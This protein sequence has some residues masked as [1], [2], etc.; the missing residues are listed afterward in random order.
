MINIL[1]VGLGNI[2]IRHLQSLL[3][4]ELE[5]TIYALEI[6]SSRMNACKVLLNDFKIKPHIK[7]NFLC[8]LKKI[9]TNI[10]IAIISTSSEGRKEL[11]EK[12]IKIYSIDYFIIEKIAFTDKND[13]RYVI[14]KF[15][16]KSITSWINCPNR[17]F[18]DYKKLKKI[19][20]NEPK[21]QMV[22]SGGNWGLASNS[23]HYID[24]FSFFT[25][26]LSYKIN[27]NLDNHIYPSKRSGYIEFNGIINLISNNCTLSL[28]S[29][30]SFTSPVIVTIHT[31]EYNY[32]ISEAE[33]SAMVQSL[34]NNWYWDKTKFN[35]E[36][37]SNLTE[38]YVRSIITSG[39]CELIPIEDS[40]KLH[41]IYFTEFK[42]Y[43]NKINIHGENKYLIT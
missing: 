23:I 22:I 16:E 41:E 12:I 7:I 43:F 38:K 29:N 39:E 26:S 5:T 31:S 18:S 10:N 4:I 6:S 24:L 3:R 13:F 34:S 37:Q 21:I 25:G 36:L 15:K 1:I 14:D 20:L 17:T 8:E 32:V 30:N 40:F 27:I 28:I 2:G 33:G 42:D 35:I 9:N 11:I 19:I